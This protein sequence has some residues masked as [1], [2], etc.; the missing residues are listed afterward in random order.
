M[1]QPTVSGWLH[2]TPTAL[3]LPP[4]GIGAG[5]PCSMW[6]NR[7]GQVPLG[8]GTTSHR[9]FPG[10]SSPFT[11][12]WPRLNAMPGSSAPPVGGPSCAANSVASPANPAIPVYGAVPVI[13]AAPPVPPPD[14]AAIILSLQ[15]AHAALL[16]TTYQG[17]P[18][19]P[20][21][22]PLS[23]HTFPVSQYPD[24]QVTY[25]PTGKLPVPR[26]ITDLKL[27]VNDPE[28]LNMDLVCLFNYILRSHLQYP[29]D[30]QL[31]IDESTCRKWTQ[32]TLDEFSHLHTQSGGTMVFDQSSFIQNFVAFVT[33]EVRPRDVIALEEL[34][35][36]EVVQGSDPATKYA[37]RF[38]QRSRIL[39][40]VTQ[41]VFCHLYLSGLQSE[42]KLLCCV[43]R[44][45]REW[46]TLNDLV[47]FSFV[48]E[49]RLKLRSS[50]TSHDPV[51]AVVGVTPT[52]GK[53]TWSHAGKKRKLDSKLS[54]V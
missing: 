50:S 40:S 27:Y 3:Q 32:S 23:S 21:T 9:L 54:Q 46:Q 29:Y 14:M 43:D 53:R 37:E 8:H 13:V 19:A 51:L 49:R 1:N 39:P 18:M 35:G 30:I 7:I 31:F 52:R 20:S 15:A 10:G 6:A 33:G 47:Q 22:T 24:H 45:G 11:P 2:G 28:A 25:A 42:L 26:H 44:E 16:A 17:G 4:Q 5:I 34:M 41:S 12:A 48:E 36:H 38:H